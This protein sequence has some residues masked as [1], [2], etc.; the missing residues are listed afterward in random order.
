[1]TKTG[2][3]AQLFQADIDVYGIAEFGQDRNS[4]DASLLKDFHLSD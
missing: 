3:F 1:M 2:S 4:E